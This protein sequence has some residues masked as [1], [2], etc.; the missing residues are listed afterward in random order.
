MKL[1]ESTEEKITRDKNDEN[2]PQL[3]ITELILVHRNIVNNNNTIII[4]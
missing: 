4:H 3:E 1:L 2:V